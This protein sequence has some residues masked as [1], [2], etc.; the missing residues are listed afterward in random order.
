MI[1]INLFLQCVQDN[2]NRIHAYQLGHDGSDGTCDCIGLI[3]G[4]L[5]LA[6]FKWAGIHGSNWSARNAMTNF[7]LISGPGELFLGEIVYKARSPGDAKYDLPDRYKNSGDLR[8][9]YH[10]GVVTSVNPL[11][12]T[13]CTSVDGGIKRDNSQGSWKYGGK[14]KYV[15]YEDIPEDPPYTAIVTAESGGTVNLRSQ[16]NTK[17]TIITRV[18]IGT[19]VQ[20]SFYN[21]DWDRVQVDDKTGYMMSMYLVPDNENNDISDNETIEISK[22]TLEEW[23]SMLE[24]LASSI[25][26]IL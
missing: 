10:V 3:I 16:P 22:E 11:I 4:A 25:R 20:A 8:D 17:S 9:Y 19:K 7:G 23:A 1:P 15:D 24:Y 13:H 2:V 21:F 14:L 12:I 26:S 5:E 6:G 18:P